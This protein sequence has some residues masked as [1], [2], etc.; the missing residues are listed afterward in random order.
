LLSVSA[1]ETTQR[2]ARV[3]FAPTVVARTG[4]VTAQTAIVPGCG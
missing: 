4:T 1:S 2:A 3:L